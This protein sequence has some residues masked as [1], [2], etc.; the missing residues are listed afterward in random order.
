MGTKDVGDTTGIGSTTQVITQGKNCT[1]HGLKFVNIC[2]QFD[3]VM[4]YLLRMQKKGDLE[5]EPR[6][7][8]DNVNSSQ[9]L[10]F[11]ALR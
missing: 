4:G 7:G 6:E 8:G 5:F 11:S 1:L 10:P 2:L 3:N 9:A